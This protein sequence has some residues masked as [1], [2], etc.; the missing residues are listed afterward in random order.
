MNSEA[1]V[2]SEQIFDESLIPE[3][4]SLVA[5]R[6]REDLLGSTLTTFGVGGPIRAVVTVESEG[7]LSQVLKALSQAGQP[8]RTIGNGSNIL[9][10]D[11]GLRE[12][13]LR[14][15]AAFRATTKQSSGKVEV[16][17]A[18]SLMTVA[19]RFSDE[20]L[21]GLEFAAGI[22]ASVG[23]AIFMNAGAHGS[24][25]CSAV[26]RVD[27][28]MPDGS[29][30][31]WARGELPWRYRFSGLPQGV[32]VTKTVLSL[33][34]GDRELIAKSCAD[35][36]AERR[37][38]QPLA[39]P[40]AG[41]VFKNPKPDLTAGMVLEAAGLKGVRVGGAVVSGLHANWIVNPER[42]ASA[43]DVSNLIEL[44][45][46]RVYEHSGVRLETEVKL[47]V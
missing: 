29:V 27:G 16:G 22:P 3:I 41:S 40:S 18:A 1:A 15:G 34:E 26:V 20:G 13:V 12:W 45:K 6:L 10:G 17:A 4:S 19:R 24:E 39:L 32:T 11:N 21:S 5:G 25:I 33:V 9:V 35:H 42:R 31:S 37:A 23:G 44:C 47:W 14:L 8:V 36:L 7:E 38:R 46:S 2:F 43:A 28:V 30:R